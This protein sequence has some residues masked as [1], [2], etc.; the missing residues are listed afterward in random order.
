MHHAPRRG[1]APPRFLKLTVLAAGLMGA[2]W[3][4]IQTATPA[5]AQSVERATAQ[6]RP[7]AVCRRE[8]MGVTT[9]PAGDILSSWYA[10]P[11]GAASRGTQCIYDNGAPL[12][13]DIHPA[14][15]LDD[16]YPFIAGAADD[17]IIS[18][19]TEDMNCHI[20]TVRAAFAIF[21]GQQ[22]G[23]TPRTLFEGVYVTI[24]ADAS[25]QPSGEPTQ[26]GGQTGSYIVSRF[27][28]A[29]SLQ[30][31]TL[32]GSCLPVYRVDI[33]VDI[34]LS[35]DVTYWLS[36]VPKFEFPPQS[37]LSL[38][39]MTGG[40]PAVQGASFDP[41]Y[42]FWTV[43]PGNLQ[44]CPDAPPPG[45][46]KNLSFMLIGTES[47]AVTGAC[48]TDTTCV[49]GVNQADCQQLNQRFQAGGMCADFNPPCTETGAGGCCLP[50]GACQD[51]DPTACGN[52][53]GTWNATP[54]TSGLCLPVNGLCAN[55]ILVSNGLTVFNTAGAVTDGPADSPTPPCTLVNQDIWFRYTSDCAGTVTVSLCGSAFDTAVSVYDGWGCGASLG[56]RVACNNDAAGCGSASR[57][58]FPAAANGQ[59]LIRV[60]GAGDASGAGV[61]DIACVP[62]G[63]GACCF[64]D[65]HCEI[66]TQSECAAIPGVYTAGQ[67]CS[68]VTCGPENDLCASALLVSSG[69][70][71]FDTRGGTTDGPLDSP[72]PPCTDVMQDVWFQYIAE[73][74]G[75]LTASLCTNT[76]FDAAMS[77]YQECACSPL[78]ARLAC[79]ND[80]CGSAG[81]P[82]TV[83]LAATQGQCYLIRIGG[84]GAATGTGEL[85]L[86]CM[87]PSSGCCRGDTNG[88][89]S[90]N[91]ADVQGLVDALLADVP[92]DPLVFCRADVNADASVDGKDIAEFVF[93]VLN[94]PECTGACCMSGGLCEV[95]T[96]TAC[97]AAAGAYQGD[98]TSC[99]PNPCAAPA[100]G[101][102]CK[103]DG[104]C[105]ELTQADCASAGGD[106][107]GDGTSC[108]PNP[109]PASP[110]PCK[111]NQVIE[112]AGDD[113][114]PGDYFGFSV[115]ID[116]DTAVAGASEH[117]GT[118]AAYVFVRS[119]GVWVQQQMLTSSDAAPLDGFGHSVSIS[120]D[121]IVVGA[122]FDDSDAGSAY[123]FVRSGVVWA[124]QAKLTSS[125]GVAGDD[126]GRAVAIDGDTVVVGAPYDDDAVTDAGS[127]YVF[128]KPAG[129]WTSTIED[130]KLTASDAATDDRLGHSVAVSGDTAV[131][132]REPDQPLDPMA[133]A[134]SV[135]VFVRPGGAWTDVTETLK[136]VAPDTAVLDQFGSSVALDGGTLL[137]GAEGN[138]H[139]G[140][141][142]AGAAY[143]YVGSGA[144]W[145]AQAKLT[146]SDAE[147]DDFLGYSVDIQGDLAIVGSPGD[148][149]GGNFA[150]SAYVF[151]RW[152]GLWYERAKVFDSEP[153]LNFGQS[154]SIDPSAVIVGA[155]NGSVAMTNTGSAYF[156]DVACGNACCL[157]DMDGNSAVD[158][159]DVALFAEALIS[160]PLIGSAA[161]CRADVNQDVAVNGLDIEPFI[162]RLLTQA[163]CV[164]CCAGDTNGDTL[165]DGGDIQG[166]INALL[167]P[168]TAR[169]TAFCEADVNEDGMIDMLDVDELVF[170][171]MSG[172]PCSSLP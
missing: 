133:A 39:Q 53:G 88:D 11:E 20:N 132:G 2:V 170:K 21:N 27:V 70:H 111:A 102:C 152:G 153:G 62:S 106:Y 108:T 96:A 109:C 117:G 87:P 103:N 100:T 155:T 89:G 147:A 73:C 141:D 91:E 165:L 92:L 34:V 142:R 26:S 110:G 81:G 127:A 47:A 44:N 149:D 1:S 123:V 168:P 120:G 154:V 146:A 56:L 43:V 36:L 156:Y 161:A 135:Y 139:A 129:G 41:Q 52:S 29:T 150:G 167:N 33:P 66:L 58:S 48:C 95:L 105:E 9:R 140:G 63:S 98:G 112:L 101:A 67:P 74:T 116:G 49:E 144:T 119:G 28:P 6:V 148:D 38:S 136:L 79:D 77:V 35:K 143:V 121:T 159:P 15:Q 151:L 86:T 94:T 130:A 50:D 68:P 30:N 12:D 164:R 57:A 72:G 75:Q 45:T 13:D 4:V 99:T 145:Q 76:D 126:F 42:P 3:Q 163:T 37:A 31:E 5:R 90:I 124:E 158:D 138:S 24:Y 78:G 134:G 131:V 115:A 22:P 18:G 107:Q 80:A 14:S 59:Y 128:V 16:A 125:D 17:F 104:S 114:T 160:P 157:G 19:G 137:I 93:K 60:G 82:A 25:G 55:A 65:R 71:P 113:S 64:P 162:L 122:P 169:G 8:L 7:S 85:T 84:Q 118:G 61:M 69:T 32:L 83:T 10:L 46:A 166:L 51:L 40:T 171:L 97:G 23:D 54:C 172:G